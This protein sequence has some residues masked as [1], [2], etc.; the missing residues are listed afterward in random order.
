MLNLLHGDCLKLLSSVKDGSVDL[1]LTD[2]PFNI[3]A[4]M[5]GRAYNITNMRDNFFVDAGWDNLEEDEWLT[6]MEQF[7]QILSKKMKPKSSVIVFMS[8]M[9]VGKIIDIATKCGFYYKTTGVWHKTNPMPRNMNLHFINSL[10]G[11]IYFT[12]GGKT[13]TFNNNGTAIHDFVECAVAAKS[14]RSLG[15]HPTQKPVALMEHFVK[16]LSNEGDTVLDP[17]MG[18]GSTGVAC[19][20]LNR[21]FI[22]IEVNDTYFNL[23]Q[24][25]CRSAEAKLL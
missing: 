13:G 9:K 1:V 25:R 22:G 17:F 16:L 10:E 2:P 4:F 3:G 19:K 11:W 20:Q 18:S 23:A 12:F 8:L 14:E 5:Q 15:T 7:F 24:S 6:N 21:N